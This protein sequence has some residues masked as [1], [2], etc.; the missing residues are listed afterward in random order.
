MENLA[1]SILDLRPN[2]CEECGRD[3]LEGMHDEI[4]FRCI[5]CLPDKTGLSWIEDFRD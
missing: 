3:V 4:G 1:N 2:K 5:F